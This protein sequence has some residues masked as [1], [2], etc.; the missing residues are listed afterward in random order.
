[1]KIQLAGLS[2]G[3]HEYHFDAAAAELGLGQEYSDAVSVDASLDRTGNEILLT[4][5]IKAASNVVCDRCVAPFT[6]TLSP[7]YQMYYV[8][9]EPDATRFDSSE[10]QVIPPGLSVIDLTED[11]RQTILLAVPFKLLCKNDCK[12]LCPR[13]GKNLNEGPCTCEDVTIDPR[14]DGLRS[15]ATDNADESS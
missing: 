11:V 6:Q 2:E 10:V 13:C 8:W 14:W 3:I 7:S 9:N 5:R 12:G 4:A 15:A 1:M